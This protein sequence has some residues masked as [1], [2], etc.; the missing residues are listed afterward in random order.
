MLCTMRNV[1]LCVHVSISAVYIGRDDK[2]KYV[3]K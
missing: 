1:F 3:L 2:A